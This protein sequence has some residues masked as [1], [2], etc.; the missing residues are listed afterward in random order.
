[1]ASLLNKGFQMK[2]VLIVLTSFA[3]LLSFTFVKAM[4]TSAIG[5][6][7]TIDDKTGKA[8]SVVKFYKEKDGT[9]SGKIY[10]ILPVEGQHPKDKCVACEG[11]L[12][13]KPILGLRIIYGMEATGE[14][15]YVGGR[16]LDP[17]SGSIYRAKMTLID[18]GC[19]LNLR[20]YIGIPL[21]GRTETWNRVKSKQCKA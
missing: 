10:H 14:G 9:L 18:N 1:M 2:N 4:P 15:K 8:L 20:G 11:E 19:K 6:W 3:L 21:F 7:Q 5:Y 12:H 13:N 16:A 17:K